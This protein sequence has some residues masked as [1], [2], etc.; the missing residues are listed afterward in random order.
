MTNRLLERARPL[1]LA[2]VL[3]VSLASPV[4]AQLR[5][6]PGPVAVDARVALPRF[7][8]DIGVA[9]ALGVDSATLPGGGLGL[10]FG[11]HW[12]PVRARPVTLGIGGELLVSRGTGAPE[13]VEG[14]TDAPEPAGPEVVTRFSAFSPQVSLNF[15]SDHGWSYLTGGF[16][17]GSFRTELRDSPVAPGDSR[18]RVFNYGG[19]ARWFAKEHLAFALDLRFYK[20]AA[21]PAAAGRPAYAAQTLMVFSVGASFK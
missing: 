2:A 10:V 19:G 7:K 1:A 21:Q 13:P 4:S 18:P 5:E 14:E 8:E 12:Y 15:G 17:W 16:G 3:T 6:P 9:S 11:A 20:I